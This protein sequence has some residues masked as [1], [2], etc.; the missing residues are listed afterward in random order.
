MLTYR[1]DA[2]AFPLD[3]PVERKTSVL[4]VL[5]EEQR[6]SVEGAQLAEVA[7][8]TVEDR[9]F[10]RFLAQDAPANAIIRVSPPAPVAR[11][12]S[13]M[14]VLAI[15]LALAMAGALGVWLWRRRGLRASGRAA[16]PAS[17]VERL[18]AELAALDASFERQATVR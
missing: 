14:R 11:N 15:V 18:V 5:L 7:G 2:A 10:R 13:A 17:E 12:E 8:A 9:S 6:A 3:R 1:L 4:E 16:R